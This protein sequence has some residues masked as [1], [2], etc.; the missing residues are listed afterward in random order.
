[1]PK[2]GTVS[3]LGFALLKEEKGLGLWGLDISLRGMRFL[4]HWGLPVIE[5]G[6][7]GFLRKKGDAKFFGVVAMGS[8]AH[9]L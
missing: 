9:F 6:L 8:F 7:L 2:N 4:E 3:G 1:M 5:I